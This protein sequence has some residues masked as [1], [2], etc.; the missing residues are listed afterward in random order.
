VVFASLW[1]CD[2]RHLVSKSTRGDSY[3][4]AVGSTRW[5]FAGQNIGS[6]CQCMHHVMSKPHSHG[7]LLR[8]MEYEVKRNQSQRRHT[9]LRGKPFQ[10]EGE[11]PRTLASNNLII[12]RVLG[13]TPVT[14]YKRIKS[15]RNPSKGIYVPYRCD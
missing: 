7:H 8:R 11:K 13:Y 5:L 4:N 15:P 14:A 6:E 10:C 9:I 12:S 3:N 2:D 1:S